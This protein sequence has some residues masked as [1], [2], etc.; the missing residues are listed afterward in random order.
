MVVVAV[1]GC[2]KPFCY[3]IA[4]CLAADF[5]SAPIGAA[6]DD[7][8]VSTARARRTVTTQTPAT[9]DTDT[10]GVKRPLVIE[11][12]IRQRGTTYSGDRYLEEM[13]T[14]APRR[15]AN[16]PRRP[17]GPAIRRAALRPKSYPPVGA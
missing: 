17:P 2:G 3:C 9:V 10:I 16:A 4:L 1:G 8:E 11:G 14:G 13:G 7:G 5:G 6:T 15:M 12:W